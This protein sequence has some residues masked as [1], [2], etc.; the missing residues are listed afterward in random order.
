MTERILNC[1]FLYF[2]SY[3]GFFQ[4]LPLTNVC[5]FFFTHLPTILF[6]GLF[7]S[8]I[9]KWIPFLNFLSF[10]LISNNSGFFSLPP[11]SL[12]SVHFVTMT[13]LLLLILLILMGILILTK[14]NTHL[15]FLLSY[16]DWYLIFAGLHVAFGNVDLLNLA[17]G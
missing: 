13:F 11:P 12:F 17:T 10:F 8:F 7:F 2:L 1:F 5:L 4:F 6:S 3:L 15:S 9:L 16:T 14:I